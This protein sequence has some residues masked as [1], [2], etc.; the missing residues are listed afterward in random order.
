MK[1]KLFIYPYITA[2]ESAKLLAE[3]LDAKRIKLQNSEYVHS[4]DKVVIN[5]GNTRCP[6]TER[7]L[8]R[9]DR[10]EETVDKLSL[11]R[12]MSRK[13]RGN[14]LPQY[15]VH[16]DD[17][18]YDAFP[19]LC[20]TTTTGHDGAGIVIAKSREELVLAPLYVKYIEAYEEYRVTIVKDYGVTDIQTKRPRNGESPTSPIKTYANGYGFQRLGVPATYWEALERMAE[21]VLELTG[22]D[23]AGLDI[24]RHG[25]N[26]YLLEVN[27]A[28]GLEGQALDRFA[29]GIEAL[30][31]TRWP[32]V[33]ETATVAGATP[34]PVN[35][36]VPIPDF[37]MEAVRAEDWL[38][39]ARMALARVA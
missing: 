31:N 8:N 23:F 14:L 4:E 28:M 15:W 7:V 17:I 18:P 30:V 11:F 2:S 19:I 24:I 12:L 32:E 16:P 13:G 25:E 26:F 39:V 10:L 27:S 34:S 33:K 36:T 9:A 29:T 38:T 6:F 1:M 37:I 5:W 35:P 3:R 21:E 22:L 20:R